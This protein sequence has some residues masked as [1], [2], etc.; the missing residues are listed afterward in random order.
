MELEL[1]LDFDHAVRCNI[2]CASSTVAY[3]DVLKLLDAVSF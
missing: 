2:H 3:H 1:W